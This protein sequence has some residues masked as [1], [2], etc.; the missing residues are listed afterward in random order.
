MISQVIFIAFAIISNIPESH[1]NDRFDPMENVQYQYKLKDTIVVD[2]FD[3][4]TIPISHYPIGEFPYISPPKGFQVKGQRNDNGYSDFWDFDNLLVYTGAHYYN[5]EGKRAEINFDE[6]EGNFNEL[7]LRKSVEAYLLSIGAIEISNHKMTR[8]EIDFFGKDDSMFIYNHTTGDPWNNK[9]KTYA[10]NHTKGKVFFQLWSNWVDAEIG[11]LEIEGFE[12]TI[13]PP[14]ASEI[15][16]A[17]EKDGKAILHINFD[18]NKATL[19]PDGEK[20]ISGIYK[21]LKEL[22]ELKLSIEG[23]TDNTGKS[24]YNKTLSEKRANTVKFLLAAKG[25]EIERLESKGFGAEVPLE[26]NDTEEGR[27][28]NRRVEIVRK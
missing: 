15:K 8:E 7:R 12:Q 17:I 27:A 2:E 22:P 21:A 18:V 23:H 6:N 25:I 16:E 5:A 13:K 3:W 9:L 26:S 19:Q 4:S 24:S 14:V 20:L 11:V 28:K 1:K 10:L